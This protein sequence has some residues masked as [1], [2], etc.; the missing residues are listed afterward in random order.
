MYS[1]TGRSRFDSFLFWK[2]STHTTAPSAAKGTFLR[3]L[4]KSGLVFWNQPFCG[5]RQS[6]M[7]N[8][9]R[10]HTAKTVLPLLRT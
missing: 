6:A 5:N 8:A 2:Y 10:S 1:H 3:M 4:Q 9:A 7:R